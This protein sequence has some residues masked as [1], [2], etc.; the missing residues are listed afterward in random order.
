[1]KYFSSM[2]LALLTVHSGFAAGQ[3]YE[4]APV[5]KTEQVNLQ[6]MKKSNSAAAND[7]LTGLRPQV[8]TLPEVD[9]VFHAL[10]QDQSM[11]SVRGSSMT[12][13]SANSPQTVN[14]QSI[15]GS[16]VGV[17]SN[18]LRAFGAV[19]LPDTKNP[20]KV[21]SFAGGAAAGI[22]DFL[23]LGVSV[24]Q[25]DMQ[26]SSELKFAFSA[27]VM[28]GTTDLGLISSKD[29]FELSVLHRLDSNLLVMGEYN[30]QKQLEFFKSSTLAVGGKYQLSS[31]IGLALRLERQTSKPTDDLAASSSMALIS[32]GVSL[33]TELNL[34]PSQTIGLAPSYKQTVTK[35]DT[36][37]SGNYA[38]GLTASYS[39]KL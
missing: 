25:P 8:S 11:L 15:G 13:G 32:D 35:A 20:A 2:I 17:A 23:G 38:W 29:F 18:G 27:L 1:M 16:A 36:D 30:Q 24:H 34:S 21:I 10:R 3:E 33:G 22:Y 28:L 6:I 9:G 12:A 7:Q 4:E 39:K 26:S 31:A 5:Q 37:R 19:D 14:S